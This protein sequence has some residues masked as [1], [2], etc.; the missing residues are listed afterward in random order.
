MTP[1]ISSQTSRLY[2]LK[3]RW[4][5]HETLE[6]LNFPEEELRGQVIIAG[7]GLEMIHQV[8]L[9]LRIPVPEIQRQTEVLRQ[10]LLDT[11]IAPG[12][13][14]ATLGQMR[15]AEQQ[16]DL[17]WVQLS[18]GNP[19]A[20][21]SIAETEIRKST[22]VS[23]VGIIRAGQLVTNPDPA[24][25]FAHDDLVAIIGSASSRQKFHCLIDPTSESFIRPVADHPWR[26]GTATA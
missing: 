15:A 20:E 11:Q 12:S 23:V 18:Q 3:K 14:Y 13:R 4:F 25:R 21:M 6:S 16:F 9:Y 10:D 1:F 17:Q 22:G 2:A 19:L 5:K 8:L 26:P 7:A 24:C